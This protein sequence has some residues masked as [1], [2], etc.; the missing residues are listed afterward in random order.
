MIDDLGIVSWLSQKE[1][2]LASGYGANIYE[3][4]KVICLPMGGEG[5]MVSAIMWFH[6]QGEFNMTVTD[7]SA[8]DAVRAAQK[9][10]NY[11]VSEVM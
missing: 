1:C 3:V 9:A 2:I 10:V 8:E 4:K 5:W 11:L 7:C 6:E